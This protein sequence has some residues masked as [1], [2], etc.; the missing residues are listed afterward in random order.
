[1]RLR[2]DDDVIADDEYDNSDKYAGAQALYVDN[3][4]HGSER[5]Q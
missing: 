3:G 5:F 4:E 1:M 2:I